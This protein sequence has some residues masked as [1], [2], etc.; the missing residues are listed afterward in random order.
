MGLSLQ[1]N[2]V[3]PCFFAFGV[4]GS[5]YLKGTLSDDLA[6]LL[7]LENRALSNVV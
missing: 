3:N 2:T 4:G 1:L 6:L 7:S 5:N